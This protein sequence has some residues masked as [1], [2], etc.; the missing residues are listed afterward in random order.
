MKVFISSTFID[1]QEER[2][3]INKK[4]SP[5]VN[6]EA[7]K[8]GELVTFYDLR[9]G[10]PSS[11]EDIVLKTCFEQIDQCHPYFVAFLGDRYGWIPEHS[12]V[13]DVIK[14]NNIPFHPEEG[15]SM[16]QL[17]IEYA[18]SRADAD[19]KKKMLFCFRNS[20]RTRDRAY[21]DHYVEN[22]PQNHNKILELKDKIRKM[23]GEEQIFEYDAEWDEENKKVI[24]PVTVERSIANKIINFI[25]ASKQTEDNQYYRELHEDTFILSCKGVNFW[26]REQ[27]LLDCM[28]FILS[29]QH[30]ICFIKGVA[31]S[32]KSSFVS[33]MIYDCHAKDI[34]TIYF[35]CGNK[36]Y[37][38]SGFNVLRNLIYRLELLCQV[39]EHYDPYKENTNH[40]LDTSNE[41]REWKKYFTELLEVYARRGK[42]LAVFI[43]GIDQLG[44]DIIAKKMEWLP[45]Y[46]PDA[47]SFIFSHTLD[48]KVEYI[49]DETTELELP[50]LQEAQ[51]M[52]VV[53]YI[54][55]QYGK[56]MGKNVIESINKKV[57][58]KNFLYLSLIIQKLLM[59]DS[60]DYHRINTDSS[61][62]YLANQYFCKVVEDLP[63]HLEEICTYI[64]NDMGENYNKN[65]SE[66][67]MN[68]L[69][70]SRGGLR[71]SDFRNIFEQ[72]Q[73]EWR[74]V[75]YIFLINSLPMYMVEREDEFVDFMH[76]CIRD[77][78][79]KK[80]SQTDGTLK[81]YHKKL[82]H[83]IKTL[84]SSDKLY[85]DEIIYH[86]FFSNEIDYLKNILINLD[87]RKEYRIIE[88]SIQQLK[89]ILI[90]QYNQVKADDETKKNEESEAFWL[91]NIAE[92]MCKE[93]HY[94]LWVY[95]IIGA[96][97]QKVD[98]PCIHKVMETCRKVLVTMEKSGDHERMNALAE[99][100]CIQA[101]IE[102]EFNRNEEGVS[103]FLEAIK[104]R[105][106]IYK[107]VLGYLDKQN[108]DLCKGYIYTVLEFAKYYQNNSEYYKAVDQ[109]TL[110][111]SLWNE[112][113]NKCN[114]PWNSVGETIIQSF[115]ERAFCNYYLGVNSKVIKGESF[116][117]KYFLQADKMIWET[118]RLRKD[119]KFTDKEIELRHLNVLEYALASCENMDRVKL[120]NEMKRAFEWFEET[121]KLRKNSKKA[122]DDYIFAYS[123][124]AEFHSKYDTAQA[125]RIYHECV[126]L[127]IRRERRYGFNDDIF[128]T[129]N[130]L[131][132]LGKLLMQ[133]AEDAD[134]AK[135]YF[136][137]AMQKVKFTDINRKYYDTIEELVRCMKT[138]HME[139]TQTAE[140][141]L[142]DVKSKMKDTTSG[143]LNVDFGILRTIDYYDKIE[144]VIKKYQLEQEKDELMDD[145][146]EY[147]NLIPLYDFINDNEGAKSKTEN[148]FKV[149]LGD[150]KKLNNA[151]TMER[152]EVRPSDNPSKE[153]SNDSQDK[154]PM[155][156]LKSRLASINQILKK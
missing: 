68:L 101:R 144:N 127:S 32:G 30:K 155:D 111:I 67:V 46:I 99:I 33:K 138:L 14:Y 149:S 10:I 4:I 135:A 96:F 133:K 49:F 63:D 76:R 72:N 117:K 100:L 42:R 103:K 114:G 53:P 154:D 132:K 106:T 80:L 82:F 25:E 107:N 104:I 1:M 105:E 142:N 86:A 84:N 75:D 115:Y 113:G 78:Y 98:L 66:E 7:K 87:D 102:I 119:K 94:K 93:G 62:V 92:E 38:Y 147:G 153:K 61:S 54:L 125:L 22:N 97:D 120:N 118:V 29:D 47:V 77:G 60:K 90:Y 56:V 12:Q 55:Q 35:F 156:I 24:I 91:L 74:L 134:K 8:K 51:V 64:M 130:L 18:I 36:D 50:L 57:D 45:Y 27:E 13:M 37:A 28:N 145:S 123:K 116:A 41:L 112:L 151:F 9:W 126:E 3:A 43:D 31:G 65:L 26:G 17:E 59:F 6:M 21:M 108:L 88:R 89:Y 20:I 139:G 16:T 83:H 70:V 110:V 131:L 124:M 129:V 15:I 39:E 44:E 137:R 141:Y 140:G 148:A 2:D 11:E 85:Q 121:Y 69:A 128:E 58:S 73:L 48:Y 40:K 34:D 122:L 152:Q 71:E 150:I 95:K 23:F 5:M 146:M 143:N 79:Q 81:L 19:S 109:Y 52:E 136:S